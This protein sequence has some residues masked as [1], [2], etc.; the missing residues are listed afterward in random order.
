VGQS[1]VE[2]IYLVHHSHTDVGYTHDQPVLWDLQRRFLD[3]AI[4]LCERDAN[5]DDDGAFRWTVET[6]AV[7]E[8][9]LQ[10]SHDRQVARFV[11]L[12]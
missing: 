12:A 10:H 9:W 3:A 8:Y 7:L 6:T 4:D 2:T 1:N 5:R 11:E